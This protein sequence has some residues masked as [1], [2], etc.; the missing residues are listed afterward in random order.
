MSRVHPR[1]AAII[2]FQGESRSQAR[3]ALSEF[4]TKSKDNKN[5]T[6]KDQISVSLLDAPRVDR[7]SFEFVRERSLEICS[8]RV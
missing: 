6:L 2:V 5:R 7:M 3:S 8:D 4:S 1:R